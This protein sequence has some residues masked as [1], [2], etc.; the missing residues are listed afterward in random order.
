MK[1]LRILFLGL[2]IVPAYGLAADG[3][4]NGFVPYGDL[5]GSSQ[6]GSAPVELNGR[7]QCVQSSS[8]RSYCPPEFIPDGPYLCVKTVRRQCEAIPDLG[9]TP[10]WPELDPAGG[11][12]C[13]IGS[14]PLYI[15]RIVK[16]VLPKIIDP[17][18]I[19]E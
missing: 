6:D 1:I 2:L 9:G 7:F 16:P 11:G 10:Q 12:F 17:Y 8:A 19:G 13:L 5:C 3:C 4:P 14:L 15:P 18:L